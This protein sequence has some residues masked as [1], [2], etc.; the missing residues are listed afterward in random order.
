[1]YAFRLASDSEV[2]S[3]LKNESFEEIGSISENDNKNNHVYDLNKKY[4]HFFD[5]FNSL[6]YLNLNT[7]NYI[8]IYNI[9]DEVIKKYKGY[10]YYYDLINFKELERIPEYAVPSSE[11]R[12]E[13]LKIVYKINRYLDYEDIINDNYKDDLEKVY[14]LKK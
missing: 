1:M 8:C 13:Y 7:D 4:M 5:N 9:P 10:G 12:F 2:S 14:S 11:L 6:L 3:I